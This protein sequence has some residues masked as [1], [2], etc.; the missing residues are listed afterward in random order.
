MLFLSR[1][2]TT[3]VAIFMKKLET[4]VG[5]KHRRYS[6]IFLLESFFFVRQIFWS[7]QNPFSSYT[8]FFILIRILFLHAPDFHSYQNP[9]SSC[10]QV[11]WQFFL[12]SLPY[13]KPDFLHPMESCNSLFLLEAFF[14]V[15]QIFYFYQNPFSSC[16]QLLWQFFFVK[17]PMLEVNSQI[18]NVLWSHAIVYSYQN[19]SSSCI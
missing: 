7:Y 13:L 1:Y 14:F 19:P 2:S 16:T 9:F 6:Q 12:L 10:S 4:T 18:F 5:V 3:S 17:P 15:R 8:R 11:L